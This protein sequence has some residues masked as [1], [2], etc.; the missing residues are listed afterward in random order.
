MEDISKFI[1]KISSYFENELDELNNQ[2]FGGILVDEDYLS[3]LLAQQKGST[4]IYW[5]LNNKSLHTPVCYKN[6]DPDDDDAESCLICHIQWLLFPSHEEPDN[7]YLSG[8]DFG[9]KLLIPE[10][11]IKSAD[12][13]F[14]HYQRYLMVDLEKEKL[15]IPEKWWEE[16]HDKD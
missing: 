7:R 2:L 16:H 4:L 12:T 3:Y 9:G 14:E 10:S 8:K 6:A 1:H 13:L 5:A 11:V 15:N